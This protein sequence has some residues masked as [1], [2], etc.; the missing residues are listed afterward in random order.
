MSSS[1]P[2]VEYGLPNETYRDA[3]GL[4]H[5]ESKDMR[6]SPH[7]FHARQDCPPELA[8]AP[9]AQMF[10]GTM[11][12]V[13]T[14]EPAAFDDRYVIG[15]EVS[16]NSNA[17]KAFVA[18][19]EIDGREPITQ[20]QK[21][22]AFGMAASVRSLPDVAPL[23][24]GSCTEVSMWWHCAATGV[25]CKARPDLVRL[26]PPPTV[27][28]IAD[29]TDPVQVQRAQLIAAKGFAIMADLKSTENADAEA[30]A[31]SVADY[32]YHTQAHWYIEGAEAALGVPVISFLFC[33]V[34]R[35]YPYAAASYTL[36]DTA[37]KVAADI[38]LTVRRLYAECKKAGSWPGYPSAT[39]DIALPP[40]YLK[41]YMEGMPV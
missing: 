36:D 41:R 4:S 15:P 9:S 27:P 16:K 14:L 31:R 2:R 32:S 23:L 26:Y 34:E 19:C 8:K 1:V 28:V 37:L 10:M 6:R 39:R 3:P 13:A 5:S 12:H 20:Q 11:V 38:N 7:H 35:E 21:D 17:W 18:Q 25:L 22:A 29:S 30:F 40:W 24:D 33:V